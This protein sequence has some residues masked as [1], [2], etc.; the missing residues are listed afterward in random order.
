M[1]VV[2]LPVL[3]GQVDVQVLIQAVGGQE[4]IWFV[5]RKCPAS[6]DQD[7]SAQ[8]VEQEGYQKQDP[9][10]LFSGQTGESLDQIVNRMPVF[11]ATAILK[12]FEEKNA[13]EHGGRKQVEAGVQV[14]CGEIV[15][16]HQRDQESQ[17][18]GGEA[19]QVF[20]L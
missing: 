12:G 8:V 2:A 6:R 15:S 14:G 5:S 18:G 19:D 1:N 17:G 10:P 4:I 7:R 3:V 13:C 9:D 16:Q 20:P 11:E